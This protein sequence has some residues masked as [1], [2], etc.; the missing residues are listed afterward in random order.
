MKHPTWLAF[1]L[2]ISLILPVAPAAA[3]AQS[4]A[5]AAVPDA[6]QADTD[7]APAATDLSEGKYE[8]QWTITAN[9]SG[10]GAD[11]TSSWTAYRNV[12]IQGSAIID[13]PANDFATVEP[14][15]LTVTDTSQAIENEICYQE[16]TRQYITDP[17]LYSGRPDPFWTYGFLL[18]EGSDGS[19]SI[20]DPF[21]LAFWV[22]GQVIRNFPYHWSRDHND[23]CNGANSYYSEDQR[24][25]AVYMDWYDYQHGLPIPFEGDPEGVVFHKSLAW[26]IDKHS[27]HG[28]QIP[29]HITFS[30][31]IRRI[32][33]CADRA[34]PIDADDPI[35]KDIR[36]RVQVDRPTIPPNAG[37]TLNPPDPATVTVLATCEGVPVR[38]VELKVAVD[39][40][41]NSGGHQH[42]NTA[43]N[44]RPRG[45]LRGPQ[46]TNYIEITR[47]RPDITVTT[48]DQ[49]E[50]TIRFLP[51]RDY[52][53]GNRGGRC[54]GDQRGIAGDYKID[55]ES[56]KPAKFAGQKLD[57]T[58]LVERTDFV[59]LVDGENYAIR[60]NSRIHPNGTSGTAPTMQVIQQL[61]DAFHTAQ[62]EHNAALELAGRDPWPLVELGIIDISLEDGGLYDS[63]GTNVCA[64]GQPRANFIPWQIPHQTHL[65]GK[66]IDIS[67]AFWWS[68]A[69]NAAQ[70][71]WWR[72]TL[73]AVGCNYGTWAREAVFHLEADQS[74][75]GWGNFHT[76]CTYTREGAVAALAAGGAES[77]MVTAPRAGADVFVSLLPNTLDEEIV[78]AAPGE[79]V[80][81]TVGV[82][83]LL[84]DAA[85]EDVEVKV[86]L[87]DGVTFVA[88]DPAPTRFD[89]GQ[90]VW[91]VGDLA[92]GAFAELY[93]FN[94]QV[95]A[96]L[97]P[98]TVL[99]LEAAA[100]TASADG[101]TENNLAGDEIIVRSPGPDLVALADL[102]GVA[103]TA[104]A[105][106]T[107]TFD[108][109]NVGSAIAPNASMT[110]TLPAGVTVRSSAPLTP[111]QAGQTLTWALGDL[112]VD[113]TQPLTLVLDLA[114]A[115]T[116]PFDPLVG[117]STPVTFT[118]QAKTTGDIDLSNNGGTVVNGLTLAGHDALV[119]LNVAGAPV[120]GLV[121]GQTV[122]YTLSYA[123]L[124]NRPALSTTLSL[125]LGTGLKLL[126][127]QPPAGPPVDGALPWALG[128]LAV[129]A[130]GY[131]TVRALVESVPAAGSL[132]VAKIN[133]AGFDIAPVNNIAYDDRVR[134]VAAGTGDQ[135]F[136]LPLLTH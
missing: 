66:G 106:V 103:L 28:H 113:A 120:G 123:N 132:T 99:Y 52:D 31:T 89:A 114:G 104:D 61:A 118:W 102:E 41:A 84:G 86:T 85:A 47:R 40:L 130:D 57:T 2:V 6:A 63:G 33:G 26:T 48:N 62:V 127:A 122:T 49:G 34:A 135:R 21:Y 108:V 4:P 1:L 36:L 119:V 16:V 134:V 45:F 117:T 51:G 8:V 107:V 50:A 136:F 11:N 3:A 87:P 81:Y 80:S 17:S 100:T 126:S 7:A 72:N 35:V 70:F 13:D 91:V 46:H 110:F 128:D 77:A 56:T 5:L 58:I 9:G 121:A 53:S 79:V 124:G 19:W 54:A 105:P 24:D 125:R 82:N 83:N 75:D 39:A 131:V 95:N 12:L 74:A 92:A 116:G 14:Y 101:I 37:D 73:R 109:G 22:D 115:A 78:L 71:Y 68:S 32:G 55:I 43:G 94:V 38:N 64:A 60:Y 97:A 129:G 59:D 18:Q 23:Y 112:A 88:G 15:Q 20:Q 76:G 111:T 65:T 27:V 133:A 96:G 90:P 93:A 69:T 42:T 10:S 67:T 25:T 29:L 98:D 44:L 30:A